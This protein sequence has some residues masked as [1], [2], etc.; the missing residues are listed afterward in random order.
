VNQFGSG[1][2]QA[3]PAQTSA[4]ESD[5]LRLLIDGIGTHAVEEDP[6]ELGRFQERLGIEAARVKE[7][8][9]ADQMKAAIAAVIQLLAVHNDAVKTD[10]RA[11]ATELTKA[12]RMM[13]ETIGFVGKS[14]QAAVHQLAVIEKRLEEVTASNDAKNLR[15]KLGVCLKMIREQSASLKTQSDEHL[16]QLKA[17]AAC[18][19]PSDVTGQ[20][21]EP[22]DAI[23]GLPG[24]AFAENLI[25]ERFELK[26]DCIVGV[27]RVNRFSN[28]LTRYGQPAVD[29]VMKTA[30]RQLAQRLP[31]GTTLCRWTQN[32]FVAI[33]EISSSYAET[34]QL[35][36]KV[37]NLKMEK[38]I[39]GDA[40][41]AFV[42]LTTSI[43]V[44][45][46]RAMAS[47]RTLLQSVERFVAQQS[48]ELVA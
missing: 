23:T 44:E 40:R 43:L 8:A 37:G 5:L 9:D 18:T 34:S 42:V 38:N 35:W 15:V 20:L 16:N 25:H 4:R 6:G 3:V 26:T 45:H 2:S 47:K 28:F 21:E 17:F 27:V 19:A 39:D 32:S 24:R 12:L 29:D 36:Q 13:T 33:T 14:S 10:H 46:L 41:A 31:A 1:D 7:S 22:L 11:H 30:T 48:G